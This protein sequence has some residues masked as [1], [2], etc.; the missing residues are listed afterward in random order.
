MSPALEKPP[1]NGI[2]C[3]A[4]ILTDQFDIAGQESWKRFY[5]GQGGV[6][7]RFLDLWEFLAGVCPSPSSQAVAQDRVGFVY[8]RQWHSNSS[9]GTRPSHSAAAWYAQKG[10]GSHHAGKFAGGA[11]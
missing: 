6:R 1:Q 3:I 7:D 10:A 2:T 5:A 11:C 4:W 8:V 9:A